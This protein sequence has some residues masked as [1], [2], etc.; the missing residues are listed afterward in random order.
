MGEAPATHTARARKRAHTRAHTHAHNYMQM[1]LPPLLQGDLFLFVYSLLCSSRIPLS[2]QASSFTTVFLLLSLSH[3]L[4]PVLLHGA[5]FH[6]FFLLKE[7]PSYFSLYTPVPHASLSSSDA[8][9]FFFFF[10]SSGFFVVCSEKKKVVVISADTHAHVH[11]GTRRDTLR[12]PSKRKHDCVRTQSLGIRVQMNAT[13]Q[14][15]PV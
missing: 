7:K 13:L 3:C 5:V 12:S 11:A 10:T 9:G 8:T 14:L 2:F 6:S 1:R 15:E 4:F